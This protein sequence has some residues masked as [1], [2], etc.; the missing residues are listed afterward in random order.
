MEPMDKWTMA[1][2]E[3]RN[4]KSNT[5][6]EAYLLKS[7]GFS[8]DSAAIVMDEIN[9]LRLEKKRLMSSIREL[10]IYGDESPEHKRARKLLKEIE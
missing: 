10:L 7:L 5:M 9:R 1:L 6:I 4:N 8:S 2:Q 3:M